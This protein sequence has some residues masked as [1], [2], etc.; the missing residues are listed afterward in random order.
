M[1]TVTIEEVQSQLPKLLEHISAKGEGLIITKAGKTVGRLLPPD[2]PK[3]VPVY[4][5]GKGKIIQM[6]EDDAHLKD[7]EEYME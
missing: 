1:S 2:P 4:G 6:I 7:F 5:R 3:G